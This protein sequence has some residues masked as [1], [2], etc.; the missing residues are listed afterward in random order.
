MKKENKKFLIFMAIYI[1]IFLII[2][3]IPI[4]KTGEILKKITPETL[5]K[6]VKKEDLN[7]KIPVLFFGILPLNVAA[8]LGDVRYIPPIRLNEENRY[9]REYREQNDQYIYPEKEKINIFSDLKE[10]Y[11]YGNKYFK[12]R[13]PEKEM[14]NDAEMVQNEKNEEEKIGRKSNENENLE[15]IQI[16]FKEDIRSIYVYKDKLYGFTKYDD[17]FQ[18]IV[19]DISNLKNIK[20]ITNLKFEKLKYLFWVDNYIYKENIYFNISIPF[21]KK[22]N[23]FEDG[24]LLTSY[25]I[26]GKQEKIKGNNIYLNSNGTIDE[27]GETL[28]FNMDDQ[29]VESFIY[30][31][32][33][34]YNAAVGDATLRIYSPYSINNRNFRYY[35]KNRMF[36]PFGVLN[37]KDYENENFKVAVYDINLE[38][39]NLNKKN[40][41]T[42]DDIENKKITKPFDVFKYLSRRGSSYEPR[43]STLEK[44]EYKE[45]Y[46]K[47]AKTNPEIFPIQKV[48]KIGKD[49]IFTYSFNK[50][51]HLKDNVCMLY[52]NLFEINGNDFS[53]LDQKKFYIQENYYEKTKEYEYTESDLK[54]DVSLEVVDGYIYLSTVNFEPYEEVINKRKLKLGYKNNRLGESFSIETDQNEI[55]VL[56]FEINGSKIKPRTYLTEKIEEEKHNDESKEKNSEEFDETE[57]EKYEEKPYNI[58]F[59]DGKTFFRN[60]KKIIVLDIKD[61]KIYNYSL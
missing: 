6:I 41:T 58:I 35:L 33:G 1:F 44:L 53:L 18:M 42:I 20:K 47:L 54:N 29:K 36:N 39:F 24:H 13:I 3:I 59:K 26:N 52:L 28:R 55:S 10:T 11:V 4:R 60:N 45:K 46:L 30:L 34:R 8:E 22:E 40:T 2:N 15:I 16:D 43:E 23:K 9:S 7:L 57:Y 19:Y 37:Q 49:K 27:C 12:I 25:T 56:V 14:I 21:G 38:D 31:S 17:G 51:K 61:L 48:E 50:Q 5:S 32:N